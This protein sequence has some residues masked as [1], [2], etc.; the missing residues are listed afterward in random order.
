MNM[1]DIYTKLTPSGLPP[2]PFL[3]LLNE[4]NITYVAPLL[5]ELIII[6]IIIIIINIIIIFI[7]I[8]G[9]I[10]LLVYGMLFMFQL[11]RTVISMGQLK[12]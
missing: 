4:T 2:H 12:I 9:R 7:I 11:A 10:S 8:I 1:L 6:M 5:A 3:L